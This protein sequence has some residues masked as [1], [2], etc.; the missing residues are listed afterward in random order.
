V[1][2]A[3]AAVIVV[4]VAIP[5]FGSGGSLLGLANHANNNALKAL[6]RANRALKRASHGMR[7][8]RNARLLAASVSQT[9]DSARIQSA[10]VSATD[11]TN[12]ISSYRDLGGPRLT[13]NVPSSGL[14]EVWAQVTMSDDGAVSLYQDGHSTANPGARDSG[15]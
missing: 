5:A 11:T 7:R 8:G 14:I 2:L 15:M 3:L 9:V 1:I 12:D 13:V 4:A 6:Q 10:A